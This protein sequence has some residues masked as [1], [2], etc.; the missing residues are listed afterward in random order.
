M[1]PPLTTKSDTIKK[2]KGA[3]STPR[4]IPLLGD[5]GAGGGGVGISCKVYWLLKRVSPGKRGVGTGDRGLGI[6]WSGLIGY[7]ER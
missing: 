1:M 6:G 5:G 2:V 3:M 7:W 4:Q